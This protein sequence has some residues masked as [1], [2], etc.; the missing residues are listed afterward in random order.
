[1]FMFVPSYR[2]REKKGQC[3]IDIDVQFVISISGVQEADE[4]QIVEDN[5][6][7]RPGGSKPN[8]IR[9]RGAFDLFEQNPERDGDT[10]RHDGPSEQGDRDEHE[11][12]ESKDIA[13]KP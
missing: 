11:E 7:E 5:G 3:V 2:R 10:E 4:E 13:D 9:E 12:H 6:D 8:V 1:M